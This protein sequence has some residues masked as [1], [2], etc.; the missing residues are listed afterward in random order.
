MSIYES[1]PGAD[2]VQLITY[3]KFSL[4]HTKGG[5]ITAELRLLFIYLFIFGRR[6]FNL[7]LLFSFN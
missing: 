1:Y 5:P 4:S 6:V 3:H 2:S 7:R